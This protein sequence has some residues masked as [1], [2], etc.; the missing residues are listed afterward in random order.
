M[1][2]REEWN[3]LRLSLCA[4]ELSELGGSVCSSDIAL[5]SFMFGEAF[6]LGLASLGLFV[7]MDTTSYL[8]AGWTPFW[9]FKFSLCVVY[10]LCFQ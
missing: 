9:I 8:L 4:K 2:E 10:I 5:K 1:E 3:L 6:L 7:V